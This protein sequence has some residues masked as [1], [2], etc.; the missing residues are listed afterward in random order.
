MTIFVLITFLQLHICSK[1]LSIPLINKDDNYSINFLLG[2]SNITTKIDFKISYVL[3]AAESYDSTA[4]NTSVCIKNQKIITH[5]GLFYNI[6]Y[7]DIL[8]FPTVEPITI[9]FYI[10]EK[11]AKKISEPSFGLGL[12]KSSNDQMFIYQLKKKGL[13][14]KASFTISPNINNGTIYFGEVPKEIINTKKFYGQCISNVGTSEW[15]C[16]V[17]Q[18]KIGKFIYN[19]KNQL[20][21]F[22]RITQRTSTIPYD[23]LKMIKNNYLEKKIKEKKCN[24]HKIYGFPSTI[25][26]DC[27]WLKNLPD[28]EIF[29]ENFTITINLV[30]FFR[31][32]KE[33]CKLEMGIDNLGRDDLVLGLNFLNLFITHFD[34]ENKSISFYTDI[35][36][37]QNLKY[38]WKINFFII[39]IILILGILNL[40]FRNHFPNK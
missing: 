39:I 12:N 40:L 23:V 6:E 9:N 8:F 13:I 20:K 26:C 2:N 19:T 31:K 38:L 29:Y 35:V 11:N 4:S 30:A 14:D 5:L 7:Q 24:E 33:K 36:K 1:I 25:F 17:S 37:A 22:F 3:I 15:S 16:G 27:N 21:S 10:Q 18:I 28:M 34:Y 32:N